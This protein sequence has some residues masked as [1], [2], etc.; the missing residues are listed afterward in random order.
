MMNESKN[1]DYVH[2]K[3][4]K[5]VLRHALTDFLYVIPKGQLILKCFLVSSISSKNERKQVKLRYH[6]SKV[7]FVRFLE[8]I[9]DPKNH[10]EIKLPLMV[11]DFSNFWCLYGWCL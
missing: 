10:F 1:S 3:A 4:F 8:E 9:D 2:A 5:I 6:S 11:L 7:E